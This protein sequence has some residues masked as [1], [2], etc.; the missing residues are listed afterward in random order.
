MKKILSVAL[1][2][3][4]LSPAAAFATATVNLGAGFLTKADGT[5][6]LPAS[7]LAALVI[8]ANMNGF[9][10]PTAAAISDDSGDVVYSFT[11]FEGEIAAPLVIDVTGLIGKQMKLY[12]FDTTGSTPGAG[13]DYG[14][15]RTDLV[16]DFSDTAWVV[17]ADQFNGA[18]N[19]L[20]ESY[21]GA[22]SDSAGAATAGTTPEV[23]EP[24]SFAVL[25]LGATA[26]V[27]R[28][29]RQA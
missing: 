25:A 28:R 9:G 29:R 4:A 24:A 2:A 3:L 5:T 11:S 27:A 21:G 26:L 16:Q 13:T 17:P 20:T 22:S 1:V 18:L 8:D 7:S 23:P 10:T 12:W 19:F 6:P 15:Y 14:M